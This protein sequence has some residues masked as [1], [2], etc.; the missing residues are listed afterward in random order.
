MIVYPHRFSVWAPL[1]GYGTL[2][3]VTFGNAP[4]RLE[5]EPLPLARPALAQAPRDR[6]E[7]AALDVVEHD[8]VRAGRDRLVGLVFVPHFDV[9]EQRKA[10]HF[11]RA[12]DRRRDGPCVRI[13]PGRACIR[14]RRSR[15]EVS[16]D[17]GSYRRTRCG[18]L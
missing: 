18:C 10:A 16:D 1:T 15:G 7:L 11:A 2:A 12:R 3:Q 13:R 4:A 8:D 9:Q 5:Q 14:R 17:E 6:S